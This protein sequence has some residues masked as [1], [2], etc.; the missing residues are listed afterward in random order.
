MIIG[1]FFAIAGG[2]PVS[3]ISTTDIGVFAAKALLDLQDSKFK[4]KKI[5]LAAGDYDLDGVSRA[6]EK[7]QGYAPW[8]AR[9]TPKMLRSVIPHDFREMMICKSPS[10]DSSSL[11]FWGSSE[12]TSA[13]GRRF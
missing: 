1:V 13:D 7:S 4:N 6:I 9:Y 11:R 8:L 5:D 12:K 10:L 3:F 2:V